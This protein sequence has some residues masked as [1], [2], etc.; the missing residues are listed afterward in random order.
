MNEQDP[1]AKKFVH[2]VSFRT[3]FALTLS[4]AI[5][6]MYYAIVGAMGFDPEFLGMKIGDTPVSLGILLGVFFIILCILATGLYTLIA[7][8]YLDNELKE[9]LDELDKNGLLQKYC[10][11]GF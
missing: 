6:L 7:N 4:G 2:F 5:F 11:K 10:D 9:A 1:K 3:K 8:H